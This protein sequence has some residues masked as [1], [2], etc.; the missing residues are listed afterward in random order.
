[1]AKKPNA[2]AASIRAMNSCRL[3]DIPLRFD[4][5]AALRD[6]FPE[7][8]LT[9]GHK[10]LQQRRITSRLPEST[11]RYSPVII[12]KWVYDGARRQIC[13][14][15][16]AGSPTTACVRQV[17]AEPRCYHSQLRAVTSGR[18]G[19]SSRG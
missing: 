7:G 17:G 16:A 19:K 14:S 2:R 8:T 9:I 11:P 15:N 1:M 3:A 18:S 5:L 6:E 4:F 10:S 12:W 13:A